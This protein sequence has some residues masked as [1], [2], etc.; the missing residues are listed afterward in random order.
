MKVCFVGAGS[1]GRRHIRNLYELMEGQDLI[2]DLFRSG[3]GRPLEDSLRRCIR[4]VYT[5]AKEMEKDYDAF[6]ITNP[7]SCHLDSILQFQNYTK[8]FFVEKPVFDTTQIDLLKSGIDLDKLFYVAAPMRYTS[9]I[10]Y[11]KEHMDLSDLLSMR[12]ICSTYLPNWHPYEDYRNSYSAHKDLGGGVSI[13]LIHEWDYIT[14]LLGI[15]DY[16]CSLIDKISNLEIDSDDIAIYFARY[17]D[18]TV[19]LHLDYFGQKEI[20]RMELFFPDDTVVCDFIDNSVTFEKRME[21]IRL[22]EERDDYQRAELLYFISL[23]NGKTANE[24]DLQH[25]YT[26]LKLAK[27]EQP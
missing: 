27:G 6:F 25:A 7:T 13:D 14:Y 8:A 15:P 1:I 23:L 5:D 17:P 21:K 10:R 26:V 19:E 16:T 20:R 12:C 22:P 3:K 4:S 18:K 11:V 2:I 24:N 9:V